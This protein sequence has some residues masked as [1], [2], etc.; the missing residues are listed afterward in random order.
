MIKSQSGVADPDP[1]DRTA[2]DIA[3]AISDASRCIMRLK[4]HQ[5]ILDIA[6]VRLDR[7]GVELL[8]QLANA[9][10]VRLGELAEHLGTEAPAVTRKVQQL[11]AKHL[12]TRTPDEQD[13][14]AVK[15]HVTDAG[16]E[17]LEHVMEARLRWYVQL[18]SDW[19]PEEKAVFAQLIRRFADD[20]AR[21]NSEDPQHENGTVKWQA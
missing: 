5:R 6:G 7:A 1:V 19:Q 16:K 13:K 8:Y 12:V 18:L 9:G 4:S 2:G 15:V 20:L 21:T 10:E 11:E 14:R 3:E 17:M